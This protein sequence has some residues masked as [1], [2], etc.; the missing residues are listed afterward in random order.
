MMEALHKRV[1]GIDVHRM[2][3]V[4]TVLTENEDGTITKHTREFG[5]FKRDMKEL[6]AWLL[7]FKVELAILESTGIYWKSVFAHLEAGGIAAWVVNAHH[8]KHV[9][10]RK[11]DIADAE[12]LAQLGRF[13]LVRGSFIPPKDLRELRLVSRY[14]KKLAGVL[15]GEKNRMHKLL[16][17]AGIRLGGV[18]SDINGVSAQ[19]MIEGLIAGQSPEEL[20]TLG[21]GS[22]KGKRE[23]LEASLD[24]DLSA[25]HRLLL[26]SLRNHVRYLEAELAKLDAYLLA[27][28]EPY[29]W[30]HQLLQTIPGIDEIAAAM[31]LIEIG[32]D[33]SRFGSAD[34]LA[35]WAAL[36]PGNNESAGKRKSG[37]TRKGNTI[38]RYLL[39]EAA[40]AARRTRSVFASEYNGLVIRRG[41]KKAIVALAHKLIRTIF[42]VLTRRLPYRD[43]GFD[44]EAASVAKNAP[45]WIKALK[46][47]GLWHKAAPAAA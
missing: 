11:T 2:K 42:F 27:A 24:G 3:H 46:K 8:V 6:V 44:Y 45:R 18:V 41:H 10:G 22:L 17:D 23:I 47:F 43:S 32:D 40:N 30:A 28:M 9:P 15:A 12:W 31:I 25:R 16:D 29:A 4:V 20:A 35:S 26:E 38:V 13:G 14:R 19:R 37:K 33:L 36:C 21:L 5:G 7:A 1:A 34:R 39:C